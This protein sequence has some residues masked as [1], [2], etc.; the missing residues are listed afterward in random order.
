M[1][2]VLPWS[3]LLKLI[4]SACLNVSRGHP[5]VPFETLLCTCFMQYWYGLSDPTMEDSLYNTYFDTT[6]LSS[7]ISH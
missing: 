1:D 7:A 2:S 3:V 5:P 4:K 6:T